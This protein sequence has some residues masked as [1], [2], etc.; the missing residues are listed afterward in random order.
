M[1]IRRNMVSFSLLVQF[2]TIACERH[3]GYELW[4]IPGYPYSYQDLL[5]NARELYRCMP[6]L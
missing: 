1:H 5:Q 3:T 4:S 2:I 6:L